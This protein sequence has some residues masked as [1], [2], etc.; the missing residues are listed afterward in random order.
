MSDPVIQEDGFGCGVACVAYVLGLS[1][2]AAKS[3]FATPEN[4]AEIGYFCDD[5][6]EALSRGNLDY[7]RRQ[8][9]GDPIPVGSIV[10][11]DYSDTHPGGHWLVKVKNGWMDPWINFDAMHPD[12]ATAQAGIRQSLPSRP[13]H[14]VEP[15]MHESL[16]RFIRQLINH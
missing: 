9:S 16:R 10:F 4:A 6:V 7:T 5:I 11:S 14:V 12:T 15:I 8:Y 3:L 1:Y 2:R 13:T